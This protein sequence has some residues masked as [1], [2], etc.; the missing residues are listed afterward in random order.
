MLNSYWYIACQSQELGKKPLATTILQ[1]PIVLFR[2][3][4]NKAIALEDRCSHRNA[5]LSQG[6]IIENSLQC[7]YHGWRYAPDGQ[8]IDIPAFPQ[9]HPIPAHVCVKHYYCIEQ[10]GFVWVCLS[11]KPARD[12]PLDFPFLSQP[13]WTTFRMKTRFKAAVET[14]LENFLDCPHA[15]Y[16]HRFWFRSPQG[17]TIKAL[18]KT[19]PDGAVAEY[20]QEPREDALVWWLLTKQKSQMKHTDRF[21]APATSR[22]D[23]IFNDSRHYIITSSCTPISDVET[24]VYTVISFKF[25]VIGW[26]IRLLFEPLSRLIIAQDVK[27]LNLQQANINRFGKANYKL[28]PTDLLAPYIIKWRQGIKQD[29]ELPPAGLEH[30]VDIRL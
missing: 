1:Q 6:K 16:V 19:L 7:P 18:V 8:V 15:T 17:K 28:M 25:P 21:I 9:T 26:L 10:D 4:D 20:F 5:P 23:Y 27:I 2:T 11:E 22:V 12:R 13:G 14:C 3:A 30:S 24:E 29:S